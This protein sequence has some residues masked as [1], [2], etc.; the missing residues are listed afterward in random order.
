MY[1]YFILPATVETEHNVR[2]TDLAPILVTYWR[3]AWKRRAIGDEP[4]FKTSVVASSIR[5]VQ[6]FPG[7]PACEVRSHRVKLVML[8]ILLFANNV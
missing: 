8:L 4:S 6:S 1:V 7:T 2:S 5:S 3:R